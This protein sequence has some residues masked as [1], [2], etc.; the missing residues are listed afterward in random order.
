MARRRIAD[1]L[2]ELDE[3]RK[4]V[5]RYFELTGDPAAQRHA[6]R[7]RDMV[8]R[9]RSRADEPVPDRAAE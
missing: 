9:W 3:L 6:E 4:I 7:A 1:L 8:E 5:E 2:E